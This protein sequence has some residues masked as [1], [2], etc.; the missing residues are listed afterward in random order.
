LAL[1]SGFALLSIPNVELITLSVFC[2]GVFLGVRRGVL[3]GLL[4][5][6][7]FTS[8]NPY[9]VAP[10]PLA[11][12]QM[13]AMTLVGAVGGCEGGWLT[14]RLGR[15]RPRHPVAGLV[16]LVLSGMV[17]TVVYDLATTVAMAAMLTRSGGIG[18]WTLVITGSAFSVLHIVSNGFIFGVVGGGAV[19]AL[20]VWKESHPP[21]A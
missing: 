12:A 8:F 14:A 15:A 13:A 16:V 9:G 6:L 2:A 17:L 3:V 7:L 11:L 1:A 18:F 20:A 4:S 21:S 19:R 5:M 10:A